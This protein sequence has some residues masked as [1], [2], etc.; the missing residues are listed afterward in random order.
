MT[1]RAEESSSDQPGLSTI[2]F[3]YSREDRAR[4]VPIIQMIEQA[5][6]VVWW[7]G[8]LEGGQRFSRTTEEALNRARA[9]VVLWSQA[10]INSHW[11]HDEATRGRD[12]QILV[13][14]SLDGSL[15]PL[16]FGQFQA[17][18][19]SRARM[20]AADPAIQQ[21]VRAIGGLH[22]GQQASIVRQQTKQR[23][24]ID[25]R[26]AMGGTAGVFLLGSGVAAWYAGLFSG[27]GGNAN[28]IA[29]LPFDNIGN[30]P[31]QS[32]IAE[33]LA[34]EIRAMLA[35]N[36][37]LEVVGQASSEAFERGRADPVAF[38]A[39]LRAGF[40]VD[41]AVQIAGNILRVTVELIDGR[42]GVSR[43]NRPFE[44]PMGDVLAMQQVIGRAIVAELSAKIGAAAASSMPLGGT[45]NIIAFDH[46]LRGKDLYVHAKDEAEER[47][48]VTQY[49][50]AIAADPDFA[51]AH[52]G[53]ARSLAAISGQ[54]GSAAEIRTYRDAAIASARRAVAIAPRYAEGYSI[55][56][57]LLFQ[58][59]LDAAAARKPYD[60]SRRLGEG[61]APVMARF[62]AFCAATGRNG[63]ALSAIERALL[64][65]PLNAL[66][67]RIAGTVRSAA[68]QHDEAIAAFRE[69]LSINPNLADTHARI[70][71]VMLAQQR[72]REALVEFER[73]THK[74]SKLAGLAIVQRRLGRE[75]DAKAALAGLTGDTDTVS[76]Y[77]QGQVLAQWGEV[78]Q[79]LEALQSA[80]AEYDAGLTELRFDAMLDPLRKEPAFI[81]LLKSM[82]L[83]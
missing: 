27:N 32:Y 19:L 36:A 47:A 10:S 65:D 34:N 14:L 1:D 24:G 21:L 37:A 67:H 26:L 55:L 40:L 35:Q 66:V 12:R 9:V 30:D 44:K 5:G 70:G 25:R 11:V 41:G 60:L 22:G 51:A 71:M 13:P 50:A 38:A 69:T 4:A 56:G 61:E 7:D 75:A 42:T 64:L 15:P 17:I 48:A 59:N 39:K 57:L 8:L 77:Q 46:Y 83:D 72:D 3:S 82:G 20:T 81:D 76:F 23:A 62:A 31:K 54:Y 80:R 43:T 52:A 73:E 74:W 33:G 78:Q 53:R 45:R 79:A 2:F 18:D 6:F 68:R 28:R 29:V 58:G 49:D 16:G 63:E